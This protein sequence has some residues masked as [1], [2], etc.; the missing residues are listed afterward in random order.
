MPRRSLDIMPKEVPIRFPGAKAETLSDAPARCVCG[1]A[2][3]PED[4]GLACRLCG[5]RLYIEED[6]R[7]FV[8]RYGFRR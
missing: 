6:L 3:L 8:Q 1:G 4:G 5:R 7:R 2:W